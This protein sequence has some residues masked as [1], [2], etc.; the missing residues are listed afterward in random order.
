M[1]A[2]AT[3]V[4]L[5]GPRFQMMAPRVAE[6]IL[7]QTNWP[8]GAAPAFVLMVVTLNLTAVIYVF[9]ATRYTMR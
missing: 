3:P 8:F 2:Y 1:N 4:L 9:V 6:E 5:G 7:N